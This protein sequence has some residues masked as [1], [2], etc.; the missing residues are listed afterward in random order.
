MLIP[1]LDHRTISQTFGGTTFVSP[2]ICDGVSPVEYRFFA[3]ISW[4]SR[5]TLQADGENNFEHLTLH[6]WNGKFFRDTESESLL[7]KLL[8]SGVWLEI[9]AV[10]DIGMNFNDSGYVMRMLPNV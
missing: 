1:V 6:A 2:L 10:D 5:T 3:I 8:R 4:I 9:I 7:M